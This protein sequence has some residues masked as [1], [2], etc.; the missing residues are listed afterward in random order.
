MNGALFIH[1]LRPVDK[2]R[3]DFDDE[4]LYGW[5]SPSHADVHH[6][7]QLLSELTQRSTIARDP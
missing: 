4:D 2:A 5:P 1:T 3:V 7:K 6:A